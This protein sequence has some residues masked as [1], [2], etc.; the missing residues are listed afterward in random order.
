MNLMH[1][2]ARRLAA[3]LVVFALLAA[4]VQLNNVTKP[5]LVNTDGRVFAKAVVADVLRDNVQEN[6]S[7]IGDQIVSL[8]LEDGSLVQANSPNGLL[9]GTVCEPGMSVVVIASKTGTLSSYTVYSYDRMTAV[10]AFLAFFALLLML[11]GGKKGV[12]SVVALTATFAC[13]LFF[14]F[15]LLLHGLSPIVA[16]VITATIV[17]ALTVWLICGPTRQALAAGIA[18]FGGVLSAGIASFGGVLS[19]GIAAEV[20]GRMAHLSGYNVPN[21]EALLFI[22][23]NSKIDVG[24]LLFAGILFASL[25]A[26]LDI[27]MDVSAA[28]AEIRSQST[29]VSAQSLFKSGMRVGQDVMGTM[30]ATLIL[31]VFGG[32]LGTWVL[33]YVYDLPF[34]QLLNSNSL[35]IVIMQGLSGGIGVILTVPIAAGFSAV[36][37]SRHRHQQA[38]EPEQA[39]VSQA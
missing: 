30:A 27:A 23:Q 36:L 19:A 29:E 39:K 25:G 26:V 18:S 13:F 17:L 31:A 38:D 28:T 35:D 34:L 21:I 1:T 10:I 15:P 37:L 7:R 22:N 33:D 16:A 4:L 20:F 5:A 6:G 24:E 12:K 3:V 14:F 32:S 8:K 2:W 9:F 11:V